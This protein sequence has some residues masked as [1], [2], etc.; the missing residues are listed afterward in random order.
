MN[1]L[2]SY[3]ES[4]SPSKLSRIRNK[5]IGDS[6]RDKKIL[7]DFI[8][9]LEKD[10]GNIYLISD[11][12]AIS[13]YLKF[14]KNLRFGKYLLFSA[15]YFKKQ[16]ILSFR[17][18]TGSCFSIESCNELLSKIADVANDKNF[19]MRTLDYLPNDDIIELIEK[20]KNKQ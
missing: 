20:Y 3:I 12:D 9:Q 19:S 14:N 16:N 8:K 7:L 1:L 10:F 4:L 17:E 2:S 11:I 15:S 13:K 5:R 6:T 18:D